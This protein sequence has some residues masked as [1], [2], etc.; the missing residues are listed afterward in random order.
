MIVRGEMD[1]PTNHEFDSADAVIEHLKSKIDDIDGIKLFID[2][3]IVVRSPDGKQR[4]YGGAS[5]GQLLFCDGSSAVIHL[6]A[7]EKL[8][9]DGILYRMGIKISLQTQPK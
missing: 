1:R 6:E 3:F 5:G 9:N 8:I 4:P 2:R 7:M